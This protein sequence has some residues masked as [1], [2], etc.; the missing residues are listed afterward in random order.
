MDARGTDPAWLREVRDW[1]DGELDRLGVVVAG[2]VE[3]SHMAPWATAMRVPVDDGDLWFKANMPALACE[4]AVVDILGRRRPGA[5]P[6]S[7]RSI[8]SAVGC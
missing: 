5:V 8:A 3:Q 6:G 4:A 7:R 1:L 2:E